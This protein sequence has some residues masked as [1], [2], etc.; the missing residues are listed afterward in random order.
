M[1]LI[2]PFV[3]AALAVPLPAWGVASVT[4]CTD[5]I[6][7]PLSDVVS[8]SQTQGSPEMIDVRSTL[9]T[10]GS[11][12]STF[13][14]LSTGLVDNITTLTD[15][16]YPPA[17]SMFGDRVT[18]EWVLDVPPDANSFLLRSM[19]LSR[20]YPEWVGSEYND[21]MEIWLDGTA[22]SGQILFD[23]V[24]SLVTVNN[25]LFTVTDPATLA[26]SGFD[27]DGT[28][29]WLVS[30]APVT[31][32]DQIT[33]T[34]SLWDESDGVWDSAALLDYFTWSSGT[35]S[36]PYTTWADDDGM[37][38]T[39]PT[40][41][42]GPLPPIE[43]AYASPK[44]LPLDDPPSVRLHG[45]G[46][47]DDMT[48][49]VGGETVPFTLVTDAELELSALPAASA[50]GLPEGG[51]VDIFIQRGFVSATL[52]SGLVYSD[53]AGAPPDVESIGP[54]TLPTGG[55]EVVVQGTGLDVL[56]WGLRW[57]DGPY[58]EGF[59][60]TPGANPS[61]SVTLDIPGGEPGVLEL[62]AEVP[63]SDPLIWPVVRQA[64]P[65]APEAV[66]VEDEPASASCSTA[67][68]TPSALAL[69][70]LPLLGWR[71]RRA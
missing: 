42:T 58:I 12:A 43:L 22:W 4:D 64:P 17:G 55:G 39:G 10:F 23:S 35:I 46:F 47:I 20:E 30:T 1:K 34:F 38:G 28:T 59:T 27:Q 13:C 18:V 5:S 45:A 36:M 68:S 2:V 53:E 71:R 70:L 61:T 52:A 16:D 66:D 25:S 60:A 37:P 40:E 65:S 32:G 14:L 24:G 51:P 63:A 56:G 49:L 57:A 67:S 54:L 6:D 3:A 26:G 62:W 41:P 15:H 29:G 21:T 44:V 11:F 50:L 7:F 69:L 33:I 9:G 19:F 48:V 8:W 31:P